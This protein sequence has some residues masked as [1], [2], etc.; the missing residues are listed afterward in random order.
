LD[1]ARVLA[2]GLTKKLGDL[3]AIEQGVGGVAGLVSCPHALFGERDSCRRRDA[4]AQL[5]TV[6]AKRGWSEAG[7]QVRRTWPAC[8][9]HHQARS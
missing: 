8:G 4:L 2:N 6:A 9:I 1:D 5:T 3:A 7:T